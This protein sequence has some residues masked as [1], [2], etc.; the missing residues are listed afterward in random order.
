M[1][2]IENLKNKNIKK[3]NKTNKKHTT[4]IRLSK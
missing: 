3:E 4:I 1:T 2:I